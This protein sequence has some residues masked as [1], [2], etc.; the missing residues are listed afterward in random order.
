MVYYD[1]THLE[2]LFQRCIL[3]YIEDEGRLVKGHTV[4]ARELVG[5]R[6]RRRVPDPGSVACNYTLRRRLDIYGGLSILLHCTG[7]AGDALFA[8]CLPAS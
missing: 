8:A 5:K 6:S 4:L 7:R 3:L 1:K 2:N